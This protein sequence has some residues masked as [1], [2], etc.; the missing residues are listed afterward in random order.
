MKIPM[1]VSKARDEGMLPLINIV[2]L[3]LIFFLIAGAIAPV[4]DINVDPA[5]TQD[6][7]ATNPPSD[8]VYVSQQGFISVAGREVTEVELDAA[9][10]AFAVVLETKPLKIVADQKADTAILMAIV[11]AATK[12]GIANVKLLTLRGSKN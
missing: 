1:P 2:F 7:P 9:I 6:S 11:D 3:M 8:A 5:R 4:A 10:A 12:A